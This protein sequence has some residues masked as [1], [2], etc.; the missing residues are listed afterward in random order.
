MPAYAILI[1]IPT[2]T[3]QDLIE[4]AA[5]CKAEGNAHFT[6]QR[7]SAAV[8]AYKEGIAILPIRKEPLKKKRHDENGKGKGR[9]DDDDD[10]DANQQED[11]QQDNN[12]SQIRELKDDEDEEAFVNQGKIRDEEK[13]V[14]EL[15]GALW[16]N[17]AATQMRLVSRLLEITEAFILSCALFMHSPSIKKR[18]SLRLKL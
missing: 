1:R 3:T 11:K 5:K 14:I 13:Q 15:R 6:A 18:Q 2:C 9:A 4:Q 12:T 7:N 17:L 16:N 8:E 10:D